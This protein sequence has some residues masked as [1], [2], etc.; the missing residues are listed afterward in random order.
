M[1]LPLEVDNE[2][3]N[4]RA[5]VGVVVDLLAARRLRSWFA[6]VRGILATLSVEK[7]RKCL[8]DGD[9]LEEAAV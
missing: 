1:V 7:V 3:L 4:C 8:C 9:I 2:V 6:I 5:L